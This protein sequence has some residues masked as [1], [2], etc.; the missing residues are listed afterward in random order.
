MKLTVSLPGSSYPVWIEKDCLSH[1]AD[2]LDTQKK[3]I[4]V[5]DSGIPQKWVDLVLQQFANASCFCFEQG[6]GSKN[7]TTYQ[8][9]LMAMS[10]AELNRKSQVI[11]L[12]GGVTGDMAGFAAATY[13]RGIDFINLPTTVLAQVDSSV[14]GKTAIDLGPIKN[15]VGA[16][17]QPKTVLIDPNVLETLDPR[18]IHAGLVTAIDLGPIKNIVGAFWQPKTVLIDPNV[19]ET[20]DPRQIHAGLVEALKMGLLFDENLVADFEQEQ[21]D[22]VKIIARSIDLKRIVVEQDEKE[23]NLRKSLNFGHEQEQLD[24][25]KIIAR[26][27]DLKRIVVEQDEKESN[28][29]KSLNFGHTIGHGI[30]GSFENHDYLH[31]ECVAIGMLYFLTDPSLRHRVLAILDRLEVPQIDHFDIAKASA[32][33]RNDKKGNE[34]GIDCVFVDKPGHF[35]FQTLSPEQ[36]DTLLKEN[37]YEKHIR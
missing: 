7:I 19:L 11:A 1:L 10:Q 16:F 18:Q 22:F 31:G 34:A 28:L 20:L 6:E 14:G 17:W 2:K 23:S 27:I 21:L 12:G 24:F 9:L 29:R 25:V 15:I 8:Q 5:Y 30:E 26:S 32:L 35:Y 3:T 36:I 33:I 13:M 37:V 4:L